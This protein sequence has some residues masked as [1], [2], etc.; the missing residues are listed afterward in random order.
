MLTIRTLA[1]FTLSLV[2]LSALGC[3]GGGGGDA[4]DSIPT[5]CRSYCSFACTKASSCGFFP[6]ANIATCDE[7]CVEA[8]ASN[9]GT[10]AGCNERGQVVGAATCSEL[11]SILG[12]RSL[13]GEYQSNLKQDE[14]A[15]S[16]AQHSGAEIA[17]SATE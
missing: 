8:I 14:D 6:S 10:A 7:S 15:Q 9:G 4:R 17:S 16:I 3:G 12:L 2:T 11:A 1:A 5:I 13:D